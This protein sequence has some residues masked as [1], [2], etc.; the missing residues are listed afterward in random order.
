MPLDVNGNPVPNVDAN[1]NP[2]FMTG[3]DVAPPVAGPVPRWLA[4]IPASA[5]ATPQP[6]LSLAQPDP[7]SFPQ[8]ADLQAGLRQQPQLGESAAPDTGATSTPRSQRWYDV[9]KHA[10]LMP[11]STQPGYN[12]APPSFANQSYGQAAIDPATGQP[13]IANPGL[14]KLGKILTLFGGIAQGALAG[15]ASAPYG[16]PTTLGGGFMAAN[17]ARNRDIAAYQQQQENV[18]NLQMA[19]LGMQPVNVPGYGTMPMSY[20]PKFI[21]PLLGLQG[22]REQM[23]TQRDIATQKTQSAEDIAEQRV[24]NEA[25]I[26]YGNQQTRMAAARLNLG[27]DADVPQELQDQFN[28]PARMPLRMLNQAEAAANRPLTT[29]QGA[30]GP[31]MINKQQTPL[32]SLGIGAPRLGG[33][34]QVGDPNRPGETTF[35]PAYQAA[36]T[37]ASGTQSA[38][39]QV[40][41]QIAKGEIPS[42]IGDTRMAFGTAMAHAD[43]LTRAI[44][45][46]ANGDEQTLAGLKNDFKREFGSSGPVTAD[47]IS[48]AYAREVQKGLSGNHITEGDT[49]KIQRSINV[50]KMG[51]QQSLDAVAAYK[52]LFAS[53]LQQ[54]NQ[55][56]ERARQQA[57]NPNQKGTRPPGW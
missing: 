47:I 19:R 29:V 4:N 36:A 46:L 51:M 26:A 27:P 49:N 6:D 40:P 11:P 23:Q 24:Q 9:T 21:S 54:L 35:M 45:A 32:G 50:N 1:G 30:T 15:Q 22:K 5:R 37:R 3:P 41:R 10:T 7:A 53:K 38:S 13:S 52:A 16:Q 57:I 44:T 20:L 43:L 28:L 18:A 48:D 39:V 33:V 56:E 42:K 2:I 17:E 34:V 31:Y 25:N 8:P 12:V 14:T 55:Q